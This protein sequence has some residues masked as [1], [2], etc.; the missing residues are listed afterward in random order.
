M[1]QRLTS[2]TSWS[3]N[4]FPASLTV[5]EIAS[6]RAEKQKRENVMLQFET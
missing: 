3:Q 2:V 1:R 6:K 5:E 4:T